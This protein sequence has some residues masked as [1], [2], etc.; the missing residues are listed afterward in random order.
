MGKMNDE[1]RVRVRCGSDVTGDV[2]RGAGPSRAVSGTR[3]RSPENMHPSGIRRVTAR[4][5]AHLLLRSGG[6]SRVELA[7]QTGLSVA[8]IGKIVDALVSAGVVEKIVSESARPGP[9]LGRPAAYFGLARSRPRHVVV[10]LG[11]SRTQLAALPIAGPVGDIQT[12]RFRT[13]TDLAVFERRLRRAV[14][15]LEIDD[16]LA[17]LVSVPGVVD[18]F[19]KRVLYS[20]NLHWT[21]GAQL[22]DVIARAIPSRLVVVQEIRALALGYLVRSDPHDSYLLVDTGDG[23]GGALVVD[24]RLQTGPLP[25]S[26]EIG[27]TPIP[28]NRRRCGC[29]GVGCL[30]TLLGRRGL[31]RTARRHTTQDVRT[32][33]QLVGELAGMEPPVWLHGT[34]SNAAN[35]I[36]GALNTAGVAKVVLVGDLLELGTGVLEYMTAGVNAHALWGRFGNIRVEAAPRQRLL[37]LALAALDRVVLAP[38]PTEGPLAQDAQEMGA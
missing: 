29:G 27:H 25:L 32:W 21:E 28:G 18:E 22:F 1:V 33:A 5:V 10:E 2:K 31:L 7:R 36:A 26:A 35:I 4:R 9:T 3:V 14:E 11:V 37:G 13:T 30:E 19:E 20:P 34:L 12:A 17:V 16:P 8:A 24:G 6:L 38:T 23:V 15:M